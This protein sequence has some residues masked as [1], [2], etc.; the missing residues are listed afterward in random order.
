[1]AAPVRPGVS[2]AI[3]VPAM[4]RRGF[5]LLAVLIFVSSVAAQE[6]PHEAEFRFVNQL[7]VRGYNDLALEYLERLGKQNP[8]PELVRRLPLEV[9]KTRLLVADGETDADKK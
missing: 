6:A 8:S 7:R 4:F 2:H 1:M 3:E 9:V 5:A